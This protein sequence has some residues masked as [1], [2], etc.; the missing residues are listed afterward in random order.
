MRVWGSLWSHVHLC[1]L[2]TES[3]WL[4]VAGW[5]MHGFCSAWVLQFSERE[6]GCS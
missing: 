5:H 3:P 6:D 2:L 4:G 1:Q